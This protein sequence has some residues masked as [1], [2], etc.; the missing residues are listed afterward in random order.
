MMCCPYAVNKCPFKRTYYSILYVWYLIISYAVPKG[1]LSFANKAC[2]NGL[3]AE[4]NHKRWSIRK[5]SKCDLCGN[6]SNLEQVSKSAYTKK[7]LIPRN[8]FWRSNTFCRH[9]GPDMVI[10]NRQEKTIEFMELTCSFE[11]NMDAANL[12]KATN[13]PNLKETLK[14]QGGKKNLSS[15]QV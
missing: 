12:R 4:G 13:H 10:V 8:Y 15:I 3:N 9:L 14:Q 6:S 11:K 2:S 7:I 5:T 1:I